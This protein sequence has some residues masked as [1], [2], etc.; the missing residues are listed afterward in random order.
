MTLRRIFGLTIMFLCVVVLTTDTTQTAHAVPASAEPD[1]Y[2]KMPSDPWIPNVAHPDLAQ[3]PI[4]ES[5]QDGDWSDANT[6]GGAL[7]TAGNVIV[8]RHNIAFDVRTE[9]HDLAIYPSGRLAFRTDMHTSLT[10]GTL[11]V[12][13]G[14]ELELG[15]AANPVADNVTAKIIF[16]DRTIDLARDPG[17]YGNGLVAF[18]KVNIHGALKTPTWTRLAIEP[19]AGDTVLTMV[20]GVSGWR[21]GDQ[22]VLPD[23]RHMSADHPKRLDKF[24]NSDYQTEVLIVSAISAGG[25][26]LT[27]SAPLAFDHNGPRDMDGT[28][29]A[30]FSGERLLPHVGNLTRNVTFCSQNPSGTRGHTFLAAAADVT[31]HHAGF[32]DMGRTKNEVPHSTKFDDA[33]NPIELGTN[34]VARYAVHFHHLRGP[35]PG[36]GGRAQMPQTLNADQKRSW[37]ESNGWQYEFVGNAIYTTSPYDHLFKWGLVAHGSHFGKITD[38]VAYN[39]AGAGFQ[40]EDGTESYNLFA[41]NFAVRIHGTGEARVPQPSSSKDK[42][43]HLGID[44]TGFWFRGPHNW[45]EEN[46]AADVRFSGHYYSGYYLKDQVIPLFAGA[47]PHMNPAEGKTVRPKPLL[48]FIN[49]EAYGP[50]A[51]G[52]YGAWVS[53]TCN[54]DEWEELK[55]KNFVVWHPYDKGILW[56]H[57]G[58]TTFDGLLIRGDQTVTSGVSELSNIDMR[59]VGMSLVRYENLALTIKNADIQGMVFGIDMPR[60]NGEAFPTYVSDSVLHN[61][62]NVRVFM[63]HL[64]KTDKVPA[65]DRHKRVTLDNV[66]FHAFDRPAP[67]NRIAQYDKPYN[68]YMNYGLDDTNLVSKEI[69][70]ILHYNQ[71]LE[72]NF[73][74]YYREQHPD[75]VI[76]ISKDHDYNGSPEDGLTNQQNWD[77]HGIS[78]GGAIAPC[79]DDTTRSEIYGFACAIDAQNPTATPV[80]PASTPAPVSTPMPTSTPKPGTVLMPEPSSGSQIHLPLVTR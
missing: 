55:I 27:L 52:L 58:R 37:L 40:T 62:V 20:E 17:Q 10:V 9:V 69:V 36:T 16:A 48:S 8:I 61:Y 24:T 77:K 79:L 33:G 74:I 2:I 6:W 7:P 41:R 70:E 25:R 72:D 54:I 59:T 57:N 38:N 50:M 23:S 26:A 47:N 4:V 29:T 34:Q 22:V 35:A 51:V 42:L 43:G 73:Q 71:I 76:P 64:V 13:A 80:P 68:I 66:R 19:K 18:G 44:G 45:V 15:T 65:A 31:I 63:H 56:Y 46:V 78:I 12:F 21:V 53:C 3:G 11:E 75:F 28:P 49:N 60:L 32:C 5:V 30:S 14:G 39:F 1:K 67:S